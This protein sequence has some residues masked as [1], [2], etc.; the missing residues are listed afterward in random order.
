MA[1]SAS[2]FVNVRIAPFVVLYGNRIDAGWYAWIEVVLTIA[3]PGGRCS[4]AYFDRWN[5]ART[6]TLKV[7]SNSSADTSLIDPKVI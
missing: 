5:I 6:F 7:R 1:S 2:P 3:P 4:R